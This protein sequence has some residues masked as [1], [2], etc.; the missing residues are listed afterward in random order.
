M[1]TMTS[2]ARMVGLI[3]GE[4]IDRVPFVQCDN[5]NAKNE[6][7]W[8]LL[9]R[10]NMGI[11]R[12]VQAYRIETP[13][14]QIQHE[15]IRKGELQ[16]WR[17][18]LI[19]PK[20]TLTQQRLLVPELSGPTGFAEHYIKTIDD[21]HILL[22]YL[23]DFKMVEDLTHIQQFNRQIGD[24]GIPH[25]SLPRTP[26]QALWIEWVSIENLILHMQDEPQ[27]LGE[28]M[29]L[30]GD[31]LIKVLKITAGAVGKAEFYHVTMGDNIHAPIIGKR[32]FQK[33]CIPYYNKISDTLMEEGVP[34]FI[35][36]DGELKPI[37]EDIDSCHFQGFDSLSPPPDNDTRVGEAFWRWPDKMVWANF[38]S[39]VHLQEAGK[40][41]QKALEL[42]E[43]G[44]HT[45]RFW[46][47]V[48][49][50]VPPGIWKKSFPEIMR[51][52]KDFGKP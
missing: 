31:I 44:G 41:Y 45:R 7:I 5:M 28:V 50:D 10:D 38:P 29:N 13:H 47:Q 40:I 24:K 34:L 3:H 25:V 22:A 4:E 49:E 39:S 2:K 26:Y 9:D 42:L 52:I 16:G 23:R 21:Y 8:K 30:L 32:L 19:T 37:W 51:A 48:S 33:W 43:E 35:H 12:W 20:G 18:I 27:L 15:E 6:D 17:D 46:I 36:M 14:C 1:K 11:L